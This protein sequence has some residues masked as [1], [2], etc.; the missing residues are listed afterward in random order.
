[1]T[2]RPRKLLDQVRDAIRLKHHACSAGKTYVYWAKR[3]PHCL[4][5]PRSQECE[6]IYDLHPRPQPQRLGHPQPLG[7]ASNS[8]SVFCKRRGVGYNALPVT[9]DDVAV[10]GGCREDAAA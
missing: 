2:Q 5:T 8:V 4:G 6:N 9:I 10:P 7:L 1:M 3:Y